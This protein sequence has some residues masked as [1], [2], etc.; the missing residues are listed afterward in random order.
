MIRR[1]P[2]STQ[3]STLFPYTT[4]FRSCARLGVERDGGPHGP[5]AAARA[6]AS[7]VVLHGGRDGAR[8]DPRPCALRREVRRVAAERGRGTL[9]CAVGARV[10]TAPPGS[11]QLRRG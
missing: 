5:G 8:P 6:R 4:L 11:P 3:R 9:P 10:A 2:R 7:D 1:P